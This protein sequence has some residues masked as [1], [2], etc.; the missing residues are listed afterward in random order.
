MIKIEELYRRWNDAN[1]CK[2]YMVLLPL[3]EY[4]YPKGA[5]FLYN[6]TILGHIQ[7]EKLI[8]YALDW[9]TGG[10]WSML[11]VE[12][13]E[14]GFPMNEKISE[15]LL[16][17]SQNKKKYSQNERHRAQKMVSIFNKAKQHDKENN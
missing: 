2:K 11:A 15:T 5:E 10:G 7:L 3:L 12:W 1:E 17:N 13:L 14:N 9:P 4:R 6:K 16:L 8:E